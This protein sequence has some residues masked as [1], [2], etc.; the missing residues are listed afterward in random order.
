VIRG[1]WLTSPVSCSPGRVSCLPGR[2]SCSPGRVS[3]LV[4]RGAI[5]VSWLLGPQYRTAG[6]TGVSVALV[7]RYWGTSARR[8]TQ[9]GQARRIR[10]RRAGPGMVVDT[11]VRKSRCFRGPS[12]RPPRP[13][14]PRLKGCPG[15]SG[16][17]SSHLRFC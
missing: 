13:L 4:R 16:P 9:Q 11:M 6:S 3:C 5:C 14:R 10:G 1:S 17:S 2:V 8:F 15:Y 7:S 12:R